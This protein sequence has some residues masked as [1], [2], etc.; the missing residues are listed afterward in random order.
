MQ[1]ITN[2]IGINLLK[3]I[4]IVVFLLLG[5]DLFFYFIDELR[6]VGTGNYNLLAACEFVI[7]TIPRK[8]YTMSPWAALIGSLLVFGSMAQNCELLFMRTIG[9]SANK[10]ALYGVCYI[11]FFTLIV[12]IFGELLAPKIE[13]FAQT[14]KTLALSQGNAVYTSHGIWVKTQNKFIH[15][16]TIQDHNILQGITIYELD[17]DLKLKTSSFAQTAKLITEDK[18]NLNNIWELN[19]IIV[20]DFSDVINSKNNNTIKLFKLANKQE[21]NLLDLN[22]LRTANIKHLERLSIKNLVAI[23]KDRM[24]NNLGIIDYEVAFWKKIVQP[25]SIL[26]MSY[27]AV[28]FVLGPLRSCARGA[29]LLVGV[30]LGASFYL[31]NALLCPLTTVIN[32]PPS[33]A[34]MLPP[35]IFLS[36]AICLAGRA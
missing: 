24:A 13:L 36:L 1:I 14:R 12:F 16:S 17:K 29:R 31:L 9:I 27:L 32:F 19:N 6:F 18:A 2:Y 4:L 23:I 33:I 11:L 26:I 30:V 20:T 22:I 8:L 25:F 3:G 35:I 34:V 10:I 7:L 15:I 5:I 21:H 28:P